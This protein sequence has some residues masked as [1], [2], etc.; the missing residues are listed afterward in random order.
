M[1][2]VPLPRPADII[3]KPIKVVPFEGPEI[4][5]TFSEA[6]LKFLTNRAFDL[7][8]Q[9]PVFSS[10]SLELHNNF[11]LLINSSCEPENTTAAQQNHQIFTNSAK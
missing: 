4:Q 10:A 8:R 3:K 6:F 2:F 11:A 5:L 1:L 7:K 9:K